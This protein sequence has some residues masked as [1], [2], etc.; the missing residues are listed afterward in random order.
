MEDLYLN[1]TKK[2]VVISIVSTKSGTGK[3]TLIEGLIKIFKCKNLNVGVLKHDAHK[4]DIDKEG[5]DSYKFSKAGADNVIVA[6]SEK[7]AMI[8]ALK[9]EKTVEDILPLFS[10][11]D[12][13][14]IE[15][16]K[17]NTYPKIEVHRKGVDTNLLYNNPKY[18]KSTYL[19]IATDESLN[20]NLP[21]LDL[22]NLHEIVKFIEDNLYS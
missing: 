2:P 16:F 8:Q 15:G 22:N 1:N 9:E 21:Q 11:M 20:I 4:F 14:I 12:L 17:T 5:K 7:L 6:S 13:V 10:G 3:T 18:D 19:A